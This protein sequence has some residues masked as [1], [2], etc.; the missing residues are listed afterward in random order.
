MELRKFFEEVV[1]FSDCTS[2]LT[3]KQLPL[4]GFGVVAKRNVPKCL[5]RLWKYLS[6]FWLHVWGPVGFTRV[7]Q[8]ERILTD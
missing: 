5:R 3:F 4:W 2:P 8:N 6:L 1:W 7:S